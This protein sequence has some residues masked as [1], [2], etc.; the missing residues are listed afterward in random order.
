MRYFAPFTPFAAIALAGAVQAASPA[1][2][3]RWRVL[4]GLSL[5]CM[6]GTALYTLSM[7]DLAVVNTWLGAIPA[8]RPYF[9]GG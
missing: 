7:P 9:W 1:R 5:A 2:R 3:R 8:F 4:S 6:L